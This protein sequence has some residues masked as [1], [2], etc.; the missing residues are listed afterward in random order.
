[1][2]IRRILILFVSFASAS[3]LQNVLGEEDLTVNGVS[4]ST[5][6]Y[7]MRQANAALAALASPCPFGAFGSVIVNHTGNGDLGELVCM[8][9]NSIE[10][11]GNPTLH[12]EYSN[13]QLVTF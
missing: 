7:W 4:F 1:M 6:A 12:G 11:T 5:R 9:V 13:A 8:G 2:H 3:S 10:K